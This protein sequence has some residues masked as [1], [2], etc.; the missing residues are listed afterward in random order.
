[1]TSRVMPSYPD[2]KPDPRAPGTAAGVTELMIRD[3]VH[4][5]YANVRH[6]AVLGP[7]FEAEIEDWPAHLETMCTFWSSVTLMSG[8]YKGQ[9]MLAHARIPGI[10]RSHF[11]RWL[12][13]FRDTASETCPADAADLFIDR[14][15]RIAQSLQLGIA[16]HRS[17]SNPMSGEDERF[18]SKENAP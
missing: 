6:D 13:L 5:F 12:V 15:E 11:A 14:A 3:L 18:M 16:L 2:R 4:T 10:S 9:P 7:I 1:M 8:R 17:A